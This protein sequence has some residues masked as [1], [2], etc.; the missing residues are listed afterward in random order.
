MIIVS[1][2]VGVVLLILIAAVITTAVVLKFWNQ[3]N[4]TESI[5]LEKDP[6]DMKAQKQ[7][8]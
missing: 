6:Q 8:Q 7:S 1:S 5:E 4:P 3:K 2:V